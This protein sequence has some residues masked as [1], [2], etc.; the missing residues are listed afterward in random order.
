LD[1]GFDEFDRAR[2]DTIVS[3]TAGIILVVV[4]ALLLVSGTILAVVL[5]NLD[6]FSL[7]LTSWYDVA[8]AVA[9]AVVGLVLVAVG[10]R[11]LRRAKRHHAAA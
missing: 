4:G 9:L 7:E 2:K 3:T 8:I 10:T 11:V 6:F 5:H 1:R